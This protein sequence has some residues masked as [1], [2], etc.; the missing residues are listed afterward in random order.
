MG[1]PSPDSALIDTSEYCRQIE[2]YL[3]QKNEGHLIRISG[4]VFDQVRGWAAMGVPLS[5]AFR[6]VDRYCERYYAKGPKR[7]PVRIEFCEAD[8]LE[9]FDDW[10]RAIGLAS[11]A[12]EPGRHDRETLPAHVDRVISRLTA[13]RAGGRFSRSFDELVEAFIRE[14]DGERTRAKHARGDERAALIGRL[15]EIDR[16]IIAAASSELPA[17]ARGS[18]ERS[19]ADEIAPFAPRMAPDARATAMRGAFER[20]VREHFGLPAI[21]VE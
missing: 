5:I 4:P 1:S 16:Q 10:R 8:I 21:A 12:A 20:L 13:C 7:R 3:C 17:E 14:L 18:H 19:A 15:A 6:G 9:L 11:A 2:S